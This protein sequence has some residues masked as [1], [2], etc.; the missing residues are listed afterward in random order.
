MTIHIVRCGG[1]FGRRL[2][3]DFIVQTAL[4]SKLA[5]VPIKLLWNRTQ[6][7]QHDMYRPAGLS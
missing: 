2:A 4:I 7:L 3:S 1:G 5:G 6:D